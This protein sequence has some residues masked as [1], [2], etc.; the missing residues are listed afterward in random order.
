MWLAKQADTHSSRAV[1]TN[2]LVT[3]KCENGACLR[4]ST[5]VS[6]Q[7]GV[8]G[9]SRYSQSRKTGRRRELDSGDSQKLKEQEESAAG[10]YAKQGS[11]PYE[12]NSTYYL[13]KIRICY[14]P[15]LALGSES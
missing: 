4:P 3:S 14:V 6:H 2:C 15:D 1:T 7:V 5:K 9:V 10:V 8:E 11:P 12:S 13:K